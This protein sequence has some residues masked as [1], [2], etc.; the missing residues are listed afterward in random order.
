MNNF[1]NKGFMIRKFQKIVNKK[2]LLGL[3]VIGYLYIGI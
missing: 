3:K 1:K 2:A